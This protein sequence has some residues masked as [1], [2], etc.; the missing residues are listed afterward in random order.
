MIF[1]GAIWYLKKFRNTEGFSIYLT[2]RELLNGLLVYFDEGKHKM[3]RGF[4]QKQ[5][6]V[7]GAKVQAV[8]ELGRWEEGTVVC[9]NSS[10]DRYTI[11]FTGWSNE[12]DRDV[13]SSEIR[14]PSS[15]FDQ[16]IGKC[17][18][19]EYQVFTYNTH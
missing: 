8:D 15:V 4:N 7:S 14:R 10:T 6:Y 11:S 2:L 5:M 1:C 3:D 19:F 16:D 9:Y 17:K 12:F 18:I 13:A